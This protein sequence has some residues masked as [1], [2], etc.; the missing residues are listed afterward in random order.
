MVN[1]NAQLLESLHQ[2]IRVQLAIFIFVKS[3]E[4]QLQIFFVLFDVVKEL[5]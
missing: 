3:S 1:L 4:D 5:L 2:F